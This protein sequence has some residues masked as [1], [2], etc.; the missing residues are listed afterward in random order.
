MF[1]QERWRDISNST[2]TG[3]GGTGH[4]GWKGHVCVLK[5][6]EGRAA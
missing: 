6:E 3:E 4:G 1:P 2:V 5:E